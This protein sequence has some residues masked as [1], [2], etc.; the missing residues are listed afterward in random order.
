MLYSVKASVL[1][2]IQPSFKQT[3]SN[4][5][6][7]G[8][9]LILLKKVDEGIVFNEIFHND[10]DIA[11]FLR[12]QVSTPYNKEI[13]IKTFSKYIMMCIEHNYTI[14]LDAKYFFEYE[15]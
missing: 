6:V 15:S 12:G 7:K 4:V 13:A 3:N 14:T 8:D 9:P 5:T 1:D 2:K 10:K 11:Q